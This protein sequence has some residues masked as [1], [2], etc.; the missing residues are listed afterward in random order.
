MYSY[1]LVHKYFLNL[2][3]KLPIFEYFLN[4]ISQFADIL[5]EYF[6]NLDPS[7]LTQIILFNYKPNKH[8][9]FYNW[10]FFDF[11]VLP[12]LVLSSPRSTAHR[13]YKE[14]S[15]A[16]LI[17]SNTLY[18]HDINYI[19]VQFY[20]QTIPVVQF[21]IQLAYWH[22]FIFVKTVKR[23]VFVLLARVR[24]R[25]CV[26]RI[27]MTNHLEMCHAPAVPLR[28]HDCAAGRPPPL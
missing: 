2:D 8:S 28:S 20:Y 21:I 27:K 7:N 1:C 9:I 13:N 14:Y 19:F 16:H 25:V 17:L 23:V 12:M 3:P 5:Y 4:F 26:D 10:P 11:L 24:T 6:L 15:F 18:V 22:C